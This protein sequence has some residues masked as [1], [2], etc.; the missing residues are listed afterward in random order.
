MLGIEVITWQTI[1]FYKVYFILAR[2]PE[3]EIPFPVN[4]SL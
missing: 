4:E 3:S 1:F 2:S